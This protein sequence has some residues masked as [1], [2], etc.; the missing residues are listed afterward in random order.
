MSENT[1]IPVYVGAGPKAISFNRV[2]GVEWPMPLYVKAPAGV[3]EELLATLAKGA[4]GNNRRVIRWSMPLEMLEDRTSSRTGQPYWRVSIG[5]DF[6]P[7]W[8][9]E[10]EVSVKDT[11]TPATREALA[12]FRSCLPDLPE[13]PVADDDGF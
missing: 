3:R 13:E 10:L 12:D 2:D 1:S 7:T 4:N 8:L 5:E 11:P 9:S 6:L